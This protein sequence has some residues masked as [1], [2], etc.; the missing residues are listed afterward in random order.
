MTY[1]N[2]IVTLLSALLIGMASLAGAQQQQRQQQPPSAQQAP[3]IEVSGAQ[4]EKFADA[5]DSLGEIQ[6]DY[7]GRMQDVDDP[8]KANQLRQQANE[9]MIAMVKDSGLSVEKYN[10]ISRAVQNDQELQQRLQ[11]QDR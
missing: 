5:Q 8:E 10:Q 9:E 1:R 7:R 3:D 4:L 6:Q 2:L 11:Q